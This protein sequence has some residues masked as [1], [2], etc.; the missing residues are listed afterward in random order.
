[1]AYYSVLNKGND[2]GD[3]RWSRVRRRFTLQ[4]ANA[5][6]LGVMLDQGQLAERAWEGGAHFVENHFKGRRGFWGE[7]LHAHPQ[8]VRRICTS[9]Y[10]ETSYGIRYCRN[11]FPQWLRAAADRML[12]KYQG[13]PR[14]IW[15]VAPENVNLIYDR[16]LEFDGIGDALA[17]MAQFIL[18]R[19]YQVAGGK[20]N[21]S[22]MSVKPDVLV[23]RV[24]ARTGIT[25]S[26][27]LNDVLNTLGELK[28][29]RPADFDASLW[30]VG[31]EF[32]LNTNP[33]CNECPLQ[34]ECVYARPNKSLQRTPLKRR[35]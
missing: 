15:T 24:L 6:F 22:R 3:F 10:D 34:N 29:G 33:N 4:K 31:R 25:E 35:L 1:M 21:Q 18:V 28:L 14:N 16:F 32:C 13:D 2:H 19:N 11:K 5:F 26:E 23:R 8:T 20:K 7:I 27:R 30:V 9:G 12:E 17:K